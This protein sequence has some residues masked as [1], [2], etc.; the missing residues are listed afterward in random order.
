MIGQVDV[1]NIYYMYVCRY[2]I[3]RIPYFVQ[4]TGGNVNRKPS[5][6]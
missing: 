1:I 6:L 3:A 2:V 5:L 4:L